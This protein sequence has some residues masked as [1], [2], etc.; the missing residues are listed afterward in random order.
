TSPLISCLNG[1]DPCTVTDPLTGRSDQVTNIESSA[2]SWYDA[3]LVALQKRQTGSDN[4]KWGFNVNYTLS[5]TFNFSNDD[6]IPFNGAEDQVNLIFRSNNLRLEK[7]YAPTD[8]RHR[9]VFYGVF[10]VPWKLTIS[11]IWTISSHVPMDS[12]VPALSARLP[13]L[14]RNALGREISNSA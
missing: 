8:E 3:L 7:G 11:P 12:F 6:Q 13:I 1:F 2:K 5:K 9:L 10:D 14:S 4:W